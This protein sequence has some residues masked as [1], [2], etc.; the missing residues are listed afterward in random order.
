M[1]MRLALAIAS[2]AAMGCLPVL[3]GPD[4]DPV[5]DDGAPGWDE[6][7]A[8]TDPSNATAAFF[9]Q[10]EDVRVDRDTM[11]AAVNLSF[12][13]QPNLY[14]SLVSAEGLRTSTDSGLWTIAG[15]TQTVSNRVTFADTWSG[16]LNANG[17]T[18]AGMVMITPPPPL[19][20]PI[21]ANGS[22]MTVNTIYVPYPFLS[23]T[24]SVLDVDAVADMTNSLAFRYRAG[25]A[26]HVLLGETN[27][28]G[29]THGFYRLQSS[30]TDPTNA[31]IQSVPIP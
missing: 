18:Y 10:M 15:T 29:T 24:G 1:S 28:Q 27:V 3:A 30:D 6:W 11:T 4:G 7:N 19:G 12:H 21:N 20:S 23:P 8:G 16:R 14:Y 13:T 2:V 26:Y 9:I 5:D 17:R 25:S 22:V 31:S